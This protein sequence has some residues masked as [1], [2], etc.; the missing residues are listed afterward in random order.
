MDMITS[1]LKG[2]LGNQMFQ[3]AIG[4]SIAQLNNTALVL[5]DTVYNKRS[6][7]YPY[8]LS[9]DK[10][11]ILCRRLSEFT[12]HNSR[13]TICES[14]TQYNPEI[15]KKYPGNVSL[16][17]YWQDEQYFKDYRDILLSSFDLLPEYMSEGYHYALDYIRR[18]TDLVFVHIRRG[19]RANNADVRKTFGLISEK[20]YHKA[21][22]YV[23]S[24]IPECTLL[25][26]SDDREHVMKTYD[27]G[28]YLVGDMSDYEHLSLMRH[29]D[30]AI[31]AN[32]TFSWWGAWLI[33][34]PNKII[35][36]PSKWTIADNTNKKI[37]PEGW[38]KIDPQYE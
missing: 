30:H 34:N 28:G 1:M 14:G 4:R 6:R 38:V 24:K 27:V 5:D 35:V 13:I 25:F 10:F 32:S 31:I 12:V 8:P 23:K 7:K 21:I 26:F 33:E 9:I 37:I 17:G 16:R 20:Y 3:Y 22:E 18:H 11:D 2:G 29:C 19:E 36:A 15:V